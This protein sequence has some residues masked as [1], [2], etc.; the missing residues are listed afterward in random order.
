MKLRI[1]SIIIAAG[2]NQIKLKSK[3]KPKR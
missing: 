3:R 2:S 1:R